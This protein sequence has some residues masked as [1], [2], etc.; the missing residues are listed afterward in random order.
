MMV[1][2][3]DGDGTATTNYGFGRVPPRTIRPCA[4]G[5][6]ARAVSHDTA[7]ANGAEPANC[8]RLGP[9]GAPPSR[10]GARGG[11]IPAPEGAATTAQRPPA[12]PPSVGIFGVLPPLLRSGGGGPGGRGPPPHAAKTAPPAKRTACVPR[13]APA[14]ALLRG[15]GRLPPP[16]P[17]R[18]RGPG[19]RG[20][21]PY[22]APRCRARSPP[23]R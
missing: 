2:F 18:V 19:K 1:R 4:P 9:P 20:S 16:C 8:R 22:P 7:V 15:A 11:L 6:A 23:P 3:Y 13:P 5:R 12:R 10:C 17:A 21:A 14:V